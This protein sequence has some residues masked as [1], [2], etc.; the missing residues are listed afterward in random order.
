MI[1]APFIVSVRE[2][3]EAA[4]I[5]AIMLSFLRKTRRMDLSRFVYL[6]SV[7]A[8]IT[9]LGVSVA[10]SLIWGFFEGA[11]L[12]I[13]EG[14]VVI[15]AS[16]LLTTMIIWMSRV[17][18]SISSEIESA[19]EDSMVAKGGFG[20]GVLAFALILREGVELSLFTIALVVQEGGVAYIGVFLGL[21]A[22]MVLGYAIYRGSLTIS[23]STFFK[24]T[25]IFLILF[26]AGMIAYGIHELQEAGLLL[27]GPL[28]LWNVNPAPLPGGGYPLLHENG[29][30][31]AILKSLFGYNGN[32]SALEV[33]AYSAYIVIVGAYF[34]SRRKTDKKQARE[35]TGTH[36]KYPTPA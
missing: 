14:I 28:E 36:T 27:I 2:G 8:I 33:A 34:I 17:G 3:V 4:L 32:P 15:F 7:G 11:A 31:G 23:F 18:S 24:W 1:I 20:L 13:F 9:S 29:A 12:E 30:I 21:I 35:I 16:I 6:G 5:I 19:A 25:S 26:A 22:S 10:L